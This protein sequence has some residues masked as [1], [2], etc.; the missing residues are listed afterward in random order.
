MHPPS[1][2]SIRRPAVSLWPYYILYGHFRPPLTSS[3][4]YNPP[5][6]SLLSFLHSLPILAFPFFCI[7]YRHLPHLPFLSPPPTSIPLTMVPIWYTL[8]VI[9][10]WFFVFGFFSSRIDKM[11]CSLEGK[12]RVRHIPLPKLLALRGL[13]HAF[14]ATLPFWPR[15]IWPELQGVQTHR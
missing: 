2:G 1:V 12:R 13:F 3:C 11:I 8:A 9:A 4:L 10:Y 5:S 7:L 15:V 14:F 6:S